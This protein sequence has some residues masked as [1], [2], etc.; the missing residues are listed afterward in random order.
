MG[1]LAEEYKINEV[2][3]NLRKQFIRFTDKDIKVLKSLAKWVDRIADSVAKEFYDQQ[4][5]FSP[6]RAFFE[7]H[8]RKKGEELSHLRQR[9]EQSQAGYFRQVFQEAASGGRYGVDYF[10]RRLHVGQIHN[11]IDLPQKWY[12][13][14]YIT[15][16]D[17]FHKH[18]VRSYP[19]RPFFRAK[20]ERAART[21]FNMD[22][23]AVVDAFFFD[24]CSSIGMDLSKVAVTSIEHDLSDYYGPLKST[25]RSALEGLARASESLASGSSQLSA[26]AEQLS[27]GV[28]EQASALEETSATLKQITSTVQGNADNAGEASRLAVGTGNSS[29]TTTAVAAMSGISSSSKKIADIITV[30]DEI[31]FQTNLLALN[32]AVEAAR[33]GEQGRGFA[34]VAV[35]VRN[36]AQ[37]SATAAKEIKS[38]IQDAVERVEEGSDVV[39]RV[40]EMIARISTTSSEQAEGVH[41]VSK[42]VSQM[43][44]ATQSNA[45]QSE[46]LIATAETMAAQAKELQNLVS[47]FNVG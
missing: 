41:Q 24:Y 36:L 29:G 23:Q 32:A 8:A 10:E 31:A 11:V 47:Q 39:K 7:A 16:Q 1:Q 45:A 21:V 46:E 30:I 43:D 27:S 6:T 38:L 3:L 20:A 18:L 28:Q 22:L 2:N 9:L 37:R 17:L 5:A 40:A 35:E 14:S 33:A 26:S 12:L 25:V 4:F 15:Y 44:Q 42:A 34:V 19:H 13:G